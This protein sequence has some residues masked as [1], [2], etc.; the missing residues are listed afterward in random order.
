MVCFVESVV[1]AQLEV[2]EAL[3]CEG[4]HTF[5]LAG[6]I[7]STWNEVFVVVSQND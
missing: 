3:P 7:I 2:I 5:S 6:L 1:A 4:K